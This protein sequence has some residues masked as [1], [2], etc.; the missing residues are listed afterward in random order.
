M[1]R[2]LETLL[3]P[4]EPGLARTC[5]WAGERALCH[6][7]PV[8]LGSRLGGSG[9]PWSPWGTLCLC[10]RREAWEQTTLAWVLCKEAPPR[11]QALPTAGAS[12]LCLRGPWPSITLFSRWGNRSPRDCKNFSPAPEGQHR[13]PAGDCYNARA[14]PRALC[15][16]PHALLPSLREAPAPSHPTAPGGSGA[17]ALATRGPSRATCIS[18]S[19]GPCSLGTAH[20]PGS[21]APCRGA[22]VTRLALACF[23]GRT[24]AV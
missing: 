19:G 12:A 14:A 2:G 18:L 11:P 15:R 22:T 23:P 4:S 16:G 3:R 7:S 20:V 24:P 21:E 6:V 13:R 17:R 8:G 10:F 1:H 5:V 9:I